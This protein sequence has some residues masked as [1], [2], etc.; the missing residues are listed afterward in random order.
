MEASIIV[1]K[2]SGQSDTYSELIET[3]K[4]ELSAKVVDCIQP[5][6]I[7][8]KHFTLGV[9]QAYEYASDKAKQSPCA[10]S[11]IPQKS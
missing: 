6:T 10:M 8:A 3:S 2:I 11:L 5:F 1:E 7:F 9:S 4:M